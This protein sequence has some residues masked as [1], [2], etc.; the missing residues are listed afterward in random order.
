MKQLPARISPLLVPRLAT[1]LPIL[2][3]VGW[4]DAPAVAAEADAPPPAT[5]V[6]DVRKTIELAVAGNVDLK[7][8][9]IAI[10]VTSANLLAAQG[11]YDVIFSSDLTFQQR[12]TPSIASQDIASGVTNSVALDLGVSRRLETGGNLSLSLSNSATET[13]SQFQCGTGSTGE[14]LYYTT[15]MTLRFDH[16]LLRGFGK[17]VGLAGIRRRTIEGDMALLNREIR[18]A[19]VLRDVLSAYW[20]VAYATRDLEIRRSAVELARKQLEATDAQIAVGRLAPIDRAAVERAIS[21]RLQDVVLA[22]QTLLFRSLQLRR[23]VGLP[24]EANVA[25]FAA[26]DS[27]DALPR[28]IDAAQELTRTLQWNPQLRSLRMGLQLNEIDLATARSTLK[29]QLDVFGQIGSTG[30]NVEFADTL[31]QAAKFE[32]LVWSTGLSLQLP[33]QNRAARGQVEATRLAQERSWL[34]AGALELDLRDQALRL[35]SNVKTAARRGV[36][37]KE[38]VKF[39]ERNLEAEEARF[40]VGRSTNN[41]VILRQQELKVAQIQVV[42]AGVDLLVA[43]IALGAMTGDLLE[44]YGVELKPAR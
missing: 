2:A 4:G 37:S 18:V 1:L 30:R 20:E 3:I 40:S 8:E 26:A 10:A 35:A 15:N 42:R 14:C 22:E 29:P 41:D 6:V 7:R 17:E 43:E 9:K 25:T 34:D 36:L 19:N 44:R 38:T 12:V 16:P 13:N 32:N 39:A 21:D 11:Q 27:P 28:D 33:A 5:E 31:T 23:L 24:A